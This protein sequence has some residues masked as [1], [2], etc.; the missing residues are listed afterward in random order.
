VSK[1]RGIT[2]ETLLERIVELEGELKEVR[3]KRHL[4]KFIMT[5]VIEYQ[6]SI[7][8]NVTDIVLKAGDIDEATK[9]SF[10]K[11]KEKF[12]VRM[13]ALKDMMK[14]KGEDRDGELVN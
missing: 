9:E 7:F 6:N 3:N 5:A 10:K 4:E 8:I 11:L 13:E 14:E 2:V 12:K 1:V